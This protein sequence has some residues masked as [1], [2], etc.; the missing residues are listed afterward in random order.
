MNHMA[1]YNEL[2]NIVAY[3]SN[4]KYEKILLL[5][6]KRFNIDFENSIVYIQNLFLDNKK[7]RLFVFSPDK[8]IL[9]SIEDEKDYLISVQFSN[10]AE[11][12]DFWYGKKYYDKQ[13]QISFNLHGTECVLTP[14]IDTNSYHVGNYNEIA[15][16]IVEYFINN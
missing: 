16:R 8:V 6:V 14:S 2:Y 3:D 12:V 13:Y 4:Y 9:L 11:I 10:R 5:E 15:E 7:S 1:I